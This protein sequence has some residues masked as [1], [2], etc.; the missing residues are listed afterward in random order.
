M[1]AFSGVC[2]YCL[3]T[4]CII[5]HHHASR[6]CFPRASEKIGCGSRNRANTTS[7][8]SRTTFDPGTTSASRILESRFHR[9]FSSNTSFLN[10]S[11]IYEVQ[12]FIP[13]LFHYPCPSQ[14]P[15]YHASR[16]GSPRV[17]PISI[18]TPATPGQ[19]ATL[20]TSLPL[21]NHAAGNITSF[22]LFIF[23]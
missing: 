18:Y 12:R 19:A 11:A 9:C 8:D 15:V 3:Y 2:S 4:I 22:H 1:F 5:C 10:N 23:F 20:P 17:R 14:P 21:T 7:F 16:P 6:P 13:F